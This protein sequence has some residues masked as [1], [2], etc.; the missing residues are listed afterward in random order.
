[1]DSVLQDLLDNQVRLTPVIIPIA[2]PIIYGG[3]P[4]GGGGEGPTGMG[5]VGQLGGPSDPGGSDA[6]AS[7]EDE[8]DGETRGRARLAGP[9]GGPQDGGLTAQRSR[10]QFAGQ[11][12]ETRG[13]PTPRP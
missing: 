11:R 9:P 2:G 7:V 5:G 6:A 8:V 1:M 13:P 4:T 10:I 12:E 3:G